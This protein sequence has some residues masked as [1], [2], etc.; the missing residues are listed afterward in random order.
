[1]SE[2]L[3][4]HTTAIRAPEP[5]E[6]LERLAALLQ[7]SRR[8]LVITGAGCSTGV[9]I[10]DYRDRH[11]R[12]KRAQPM[13]LRTFL[14]SEGARR[15]YW[16]RSFVGWPT[17]AEARPGESHRLLAALQERGYIHDLVTQNVDGLHTAAGS[18][19]VIELHGSLH[20]VVCRGC[21]AQLGRGALQERLAALNPGWRAD[22]SMR[23][24]GDAELGDA[25]ATDFRIPGCA[26]C[27]GI[28]KPDVIFFGENVPQPRVAD[29]YTRLAA[30][31]LLL[32]VG[33]SLM[34]WSGY[35]F[36]REAVRLGLPIAAINA[37]RTRAD[38][39]LSLKLEAPCEDTLAALDRLLSRAGA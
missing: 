5:P 31:D 11:G 29:V 23:P 2:S 8:T 6:G 18:E 7:Q 22:G 25:D 12:W 32:V 13:Q 10:P 28:L 19:P 30:A 35:R 3:S 9:G 34:V 39:E 16:S 17:V 20:R 1:M 37:G 21:G 4:C 15:R 27:G 24:D 38:D 26:H 33:S 14:G 36:A